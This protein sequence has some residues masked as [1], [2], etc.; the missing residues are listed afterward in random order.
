MGLFQSLSSLALRQVVHAAC[1]AAGVSE[2]GQAVVGLLEERLCDRSQRLVSALQAANERAWT[3]LEVALAGDSLWGR[4]KLALAR[5]EDQAFRQQV[6]AFLDATSFAASPESRQECLQELRKARKS[7]LLTGGDLHP[8]QL[9]RQAGSFA[10][11]SDPARLLDAEWQAVEGMVQELREAGCPNL[12]RLLAARPP[13]GMPL[14]VVAGRYFF[15][16]QVEADP[17]LF[18]GLAFAQLERLGQ[19]QERGFAALEAAL[20]QQGRRLEALLGEVRAVVVETHGAVLGLQE[21]MVGQGERLKE[22]GAAVQKLLEQHQLQRRAVRPGD[23]LSI[24]NDAE[25]E[26]VKQLVAR[27]RSLPETERKQ[28]PAVLNA[29]GKLE[30]VAG[31]FDAAQRDFQAAATIATGSEAQAEAHYNAYQAALQRRDWA[32]AVKS[33]IRSVQ[34]D[35]RAFMPFPMAKY[36]PQRILGAGG[37]GV[38]FLCRHKFMD[39]QVV[40]KTLTLEDLGREADK[41]FAEAQLLRELDHP[42]IV[43]ISDC[44]YVDPAGKSRPFLVMD[45]F[46]GTTLEEHVRKHGPLP[47][48]ELLAVARPVAEALQAAHARGILHRDVKPANLLVRNEAGR[49]R[50]KVIDFGLAMR[51]KVV[52][53]GGTASTSRRGKTLVGGSIAGTLDYAAPEQMGRREGEAVGPY[54]DVYGWAKTCCF[55]LFQT[56]QPLLSHWRSI[57]GPLAELLE[58]CLEEDPKKRTQG[59]A[60]VLRGLCSAA[61]PP[62]RLEPPA[63]H[64][65]P[66]EEPEEVEGPQRPRPRKVLVAPGRQV[67]PWLVGGMA[68]FTL[69]VV[70]LVVL[71]VSTSGKRPGD[72][73]SAKTGQP[74]AATPPSRKVE[75]DLPRG[76]TPPVKDE[77]EPEAPR[78]RLIPPAR[79]GPPGEKGE[80]NRQ[81]PPS[82]S[83]EGKTPSRTGEQASGKVPD[84]WQ[85]ILEVGNAKWEGDFLRLEPWSV[86]SSKDAFTGWVDVTVVARTDTGT[87]RL[88]AARGSAVILDWDTSPPQLRVHRPDGN[89]RME[90]GSLA[91]TRPQTMKLNTWHTVR[92]L[93]TPKGM[94]VWLDEIKVFEEKRAY[95]LS[96]K[97]RV[98]VGSRKN[99]LDIKSF[100]VR[101]SW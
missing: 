69:A 73:A 35:A 48:N 56:T 49:W 9:A 96:A 66:V 85:R 31:D 32:E 84:A 37:F 3:A 52:R 59:F 38:A 93:V 78:P 23:S 14:L 71:A 87:I 45:Y 63:D 67:W 83:R 74:K 86:V 6:R 95:D 58:R 82:E 7:G 53:E 5:G 55:A 61:A 43:R 10:R 101:T 100:G 68:L 2:V 79:L 27:Y 77:G 75:D 97:Y 47:V 76:Q 18:Q 42:G 60:E 21:Q 36:L 44:G 30:V 88:F 17:Q 57:P 41:V 4:C 62:P 25:R 13:E 15:R 99:Q 33:L 50:V 64:A 28:A 26:L 89:V 72:T 22:I 51:Q 98:T 20:T 40:V 11:F 24:R 8:R 65:R 19:T 16:R 90:S 80:S 91:R 54:S 81:A 29:V 1:K 34:C 92:W 70:L 46:E 94:T 39:A 12:G